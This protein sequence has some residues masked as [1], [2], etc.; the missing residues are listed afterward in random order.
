M[1]DIYPE[2]TA[3]GP[4]TTEPDLFP[5]P[6]PWCVSCG[7]QHQ[8]DEH[9]PECTGEHSAGCCLTP[10][11]VAE[12]ARVDLCGL[13][14]RVDRAA[15]ALHAQVVDVLTAEGGRRTSP[16]QERR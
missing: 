11:A 13:C 5:E 4:R 9:C 10:E 7:F 16:Q 15:M 2:G 6:Y 1:R 3:C 12:L 8:D 14:E